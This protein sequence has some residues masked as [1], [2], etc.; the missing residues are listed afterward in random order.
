MDL[1]IYDRQDGLQGVLD[2]T[3]SVRWRRKYFEPGEVEIHLPATRENVELLAEGRI[4]RRTDRVEAA[5]IEGVEVDGEDLGITGRMLSS[6]LERAI[7]SKRYTLRGPTERVM[8]ALIPEGARVVPELAAARES[9]VGGGSVEMQATYKNLLTVEERLA[10]ASGLGFRVRFEPGV[11]TFEVYAGTDRSVQ[12]RD[13]PVVIFSDEFGNLA[14]P[15]YIKTS[16]GY[17]NRAYV[18]GEGEGTDRTVVVVDLSAGEE[19]RELYVDAR[20][21][22]REEGVAEADYK[23]MLYQRGLEKLAECE[24]VEYFE[25]GGEDVENFAYMVDW[26]LGDIVTVQ[27]ARLGLTMHERITEVEEVYE[28]GVATYTP[29]FGSPLPEKLNLGDDTE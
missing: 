20:D 13:R 28:R 12:Q 19:V 7:L 4:I 6:L 9:G 23:A 21:L 22:Q 25:S 24:K 2:A 16:A 3:T 1:Y 17:K 29:T 14:A 5:I 26:D 8:L 27:Y 10:N 11:M 18:A 15:R